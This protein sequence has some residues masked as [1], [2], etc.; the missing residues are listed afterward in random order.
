M[1]RAQGA[2]SITNLEGFKDLRGLRLSGLSPKLIEIG[3]TDTKLEQTKSVTKP[4]SQG[5]IKGK[6]VLARSRATFNVSGSSVGS[7]THQAANKPF[8]FTSLPNHAIINGRP[9]QGATIKAQYT[10]SEGSNMGNQVLAH[11]QV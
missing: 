7:S 10:T 11:S 2:C 8:L 4:S 1:D 5:S 3:K 6:K 9:E